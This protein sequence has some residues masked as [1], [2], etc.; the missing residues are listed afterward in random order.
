MWIA[1]KNILDYTKGV[2]FEGFC[3]SPMMIDAV[4]RNIEILGEAA[5]RITEDLKKKY[6]DIEW[7]EIARTRD[8]IIHFYFGVDLEI[9]WDIVLNYVP[10]LQKKLET[11]IKKEGWD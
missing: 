2:K 10:E 6:V 1:C 3:Q 7:S 11:L 8:K 5:K 9:I 4:V